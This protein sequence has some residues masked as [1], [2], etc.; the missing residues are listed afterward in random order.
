MLVGNTDIN[1]EGPGNRIATMVSTRDANLSTGLDPLNLDVNVTVRKSVTVGEVLM[2]DMAQSDGAVASATIGAT[3]SSWRNVIAPTAAGLAAGYPLCVSLAIIADNA[4]GSVRV[5]GVVAADLA[6]TNVLGD[7]LVATTSGTLARALSGINQRV[8]AWALVAGATEQSVY[9]DGFGGFGA[10]QNPLPTGLQVGNV[11]IL[12][13]NRTGSTQVIGDVLMLDMIQADGDTTNATLG[14]TGSC[15]A[16]VLVPTTAAIVA[17]LPLCVALE[18]NVNDAVGSYRIE[19]IVDALSANTWVLGDDLVGIN[20]ALGFDKT[21]AATEHV[22]AIALEAGTGVRLCWLR[23][24]GG[25]G[26]AA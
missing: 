24:V 22:Y 9:F 13:T 15:W 1:V 10:V 3:D 20:A 19:G 14:D 8:V 11:D 16:N 25:F 7:Q 12:C 26:G 18:T 23:G 5:R 2:F 17:G 6:G 4:A 21:V